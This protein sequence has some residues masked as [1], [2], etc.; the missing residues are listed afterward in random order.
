MRLKVQEALK[1]EIKPG[2]IFIY[3][4][5]EYLTKQFIKKALKGVKYETFYPDSLKELLS[6]TGSSLFEGKVVPI[7]LHAEEL[8]G[9]LRKKAEKEAFLKKLKSLD[10][11]IIA[12]FGELDWKTLKGELFKGIIE[13]SE[14]VIESEPYTEKQIYGLIAKK[15]KSAGREL[16]PELIKLIVEIVGTD[17]TE[18]KHET[19]KLLLYPGELNRETI[20]ALLF[21]SGKVNPFELVFP[22]V[23][24]REREFL[25]E[26]SELL[27]RG[28]EPLQILGL[29]QSQVRSMVEI[30]SGRSV[31]L[32][33]E[34]LQKYRQVA[35]GVGLIKLL[36]LL[37]ELHTA[38]FSI[39]SGLKGGKEALRELAF[40]R[41][42]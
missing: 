27:S 35:K 29:L 34:A 15:F 14:I 39:K 10:S 28:S 18:L 25:R 24:G 21:S 5:E 20:E 23:E 1:K 4:S 22:L 30:A 42:S 12:A 17:L 38:E 19:D 13:T 33:K 16:P 36:K 3:G 6:F 41:A 26:L 11:F 32:P 37:K 2:K 8:P 40:K 9:K 31:R 7:L